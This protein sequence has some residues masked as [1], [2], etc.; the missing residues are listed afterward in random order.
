[1]NLFKQWTNLNYPNPIDL[2]TT[3]NL[4]ESETYEFLTSRIRKVSNRF[5]MHL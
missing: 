1:M 2:Q 3:L 5:Q 4:S